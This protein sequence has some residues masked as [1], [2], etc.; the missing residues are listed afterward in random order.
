MRFLVS[1]RYSL[2]LTSFLT[3]YNDLVVF[4]RPVYPVLA[5]LPFTFLVKRTGK[6]SLIAYDG[7]KQSII[8]SGFEV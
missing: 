6:W 8:F 4:A 7:T 3:V 2:T 5:T 1:L